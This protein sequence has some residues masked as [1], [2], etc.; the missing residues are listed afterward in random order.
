MGLRSQNISRVGGG[1]PREKRRGAHNGQRSNLKSAWRREKTTRAISE[2]DG[3]ERRLQR[4][5]MTK[6]ILQLFD[7]ISSSPDDIGY[8]CA[9]TR[10]K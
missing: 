5:P 10:P 8:G 1:R 9:D 3:M 4:E 6:P 7:V 2:L